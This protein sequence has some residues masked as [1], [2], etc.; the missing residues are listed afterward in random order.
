MRLDDSEC[1][2]MFN[3]EQGIWS[4]VL[5][6]AP[7]LFNTF[8]SRRGCAWPRN[9]SS[10][11]STDDAAIMDSTAKSHRSLIERRGRRKRRPNTGVG[12][13]DAGRGKDNAAPDIVGNAV[14]VDDAGI[15]SRSPQKGRRGR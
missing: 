13:V 1:A 4:R 2:D 15:V 3:V 12:T 8:F 5:V 9:A 7:P 11:N 6:L 10:R 14:H